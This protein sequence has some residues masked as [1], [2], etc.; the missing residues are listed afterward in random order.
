[1][2]SL[3]KNNRTSI[4]CMCTKSRTHCVRDFVH[5]QCIS[6]S[7][8]NCMCTKSRTQC[9]RDFVHIQFEIAIFVEFRWISVRNSR[10]GVFATLCTYSAFGYLDSTVC[11]QSREHTVFATLCTYSTKWRCVRDFVHIQTRYTVHGRGAK[12]P[13]I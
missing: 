12:S 8:A 11:A 1:M 10:F 3:Q 2:Y 13:G 9:V 5:I 6:L 4:I 7:G